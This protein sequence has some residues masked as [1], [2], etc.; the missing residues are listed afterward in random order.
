MRK[1][2]SFEGK[3]I[4]VTGHSGFSGTWLCHLLQL[5]GANVLGFSRDSSSFSTLFPDNELSARF[6]TV[7]GMVED[8]AALTATVSA[9]EPHLVVHLAAQSLVLQGY[10]DPVGT[11]KTNTLGTAQVLQSAL[12][13]SAL[14][15]VLVITTDKVYAE[16]PEV[17]YEDSFLGGSDPYSCSK[18]GAEEVVK[19]FRSTYELSGVSLT[20]IRGG[21]IIGGGD[22]SKNRIV[23]DLIKASS[24]EGSL[25]LRNPD[26]VRPWQHVMDLVFAYS[27]VAWNMVHSPSNHV[28]TE[29]NVGPSPT[30]AL[31]VVELVKLFSDSGFPVKSSVRPESQYEAPSLRI[32]SDKIQA[33]LSWRSR[34]S[35]QQ[36]VKLTADWY[37][38][39]VQLRLNPHE[40]TRRQILKYVNHE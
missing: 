30:A 25:V 2:P 24:E 26:S 37:K 27:L 5:Q 39:V 8:G 21:N 32:N 28:N 19:A 18:V 16:G 6:P 9:F 40:V 31:S 23:P 7:F 20:V 4:L 33:A 22:W 11:F 14:I 38:D 12:G 13:S 10:A 15:G 3:R 36:A 17:K 34:L 1:I 29:Y 35:A